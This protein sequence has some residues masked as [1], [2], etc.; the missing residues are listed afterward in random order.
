MLFGVVVLL[1]SRLLW[2]V[3]SPQL[4]PVRAVRIWVKVRLPKQDS[5]RRSGIWRP[6]TWFLLLIVIFDHSLLF[7]S[8]SSSYKYRVF[9]EQQWFIQ[10]RFELWWLGLLFFYP[11]RSTRVFM[12]FLAN[13]TKVRTLALLLQFF[14]WNLLIV[15]KASFEYILIVF[16]EAHLRLSIFCLRRLTQLTLAF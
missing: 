6:P 1:V 7:L 8:A 9:W 2:I 12:G 16:L 10:I 11:L 13:L 14:S 4:F 15:T 3:F 5:R